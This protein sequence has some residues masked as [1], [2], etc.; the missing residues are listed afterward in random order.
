M[1]LLLG[2]FAVMIAGYFGVDKTTGKSSENR[3]G[4]TVR[5]EVSYGFEVKDEEKLVGFAE[6]VFTGRVIEQVGSEEMPD[7]KAEGPG[8]PQTQYA[9]EPLENVKGDLTE[10]VTVNQQGGTLKQNGKSKKVLIEG[11]PLLEPGKEYMFVTRYEKNKDW[12]TIAAQPFGD[13]KIE[14]KEKR[15]QTKE[16]FEKAKKNQKDPSKE[17][18]KK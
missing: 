6:N 4:D 16:E 13:V 11:D 7:P 17:F 12:Y 9:V 8:I 2:I 18:S 5:M 3:D 1:F 15:K 14:D 10:P